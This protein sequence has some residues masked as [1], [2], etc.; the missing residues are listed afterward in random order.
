MNDEITIECRLVSKVFTND[1]GEEITYHQLIYDYE[2]EE[3]TIPVK[4]T[5]AQMIRIIEKAN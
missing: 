2:D 3:I 4:K 5:V 1:D